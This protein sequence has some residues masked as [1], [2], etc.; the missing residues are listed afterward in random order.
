MHESMWVAFRAVPSASAGR[1]LELDGVLAGI[2]PAVPE[3]S[4]PNSVLYRSEDDLIAALPAARGGLRRRRRAGLDGVGA[5]AP[6]P[7][8]PGAGRRRAR[9]R[10]HSHG[11]DRPARRGRGAAARRRGPRPGALAA[12]PGRDQRPRVRHGRRLPA[13]PRRGRRG[14]P[15]QLHRDGRRPR[16]GQRGEPGPR[17]RHQH[18]VGGR[19]P[20]GPRPGHRVGP[21]APRPGR[22]PRAG[23]G[24]EHPP[25]HEAGAA[26]V[27]APGLPAL[28][29]DRDV[30]DGRPRGERRRAAA[31]RWA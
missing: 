13:H 16:G 30:G 27:R 26:G 8:A 17:G 12:G 20:G 2:T 11:H 14:S 6:R 21:D 23:L 5:G 4:L 28:R 1:C 9:A 25:G 19:G 24:G 18:V 10:R 22:R 3:R 15:L 29:N 31:L 7:G